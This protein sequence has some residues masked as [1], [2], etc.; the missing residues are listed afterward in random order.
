MQHI[1]L[2]RKHLIL[3]KHSPTV[4]VHNNGEP[5]SQSCSWHLCPII[6]AGH[7]DDNNKESGEHVLCEDAVSY[8]RSW[9]QGD[10]AS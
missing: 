6:N 1:P 3:Y 2:R 7:D 9:L 8:P 5:N 4:D 10:T